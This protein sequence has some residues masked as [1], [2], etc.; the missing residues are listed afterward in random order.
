LKSYLATL[1]GNDVVSLAS[2]RLENGVTTHTILGPFTRDGTV[3]LAAIDEFFGPAGDRP[4]VQASLLDSIRRA[5]SADTGDVQDVQRTVLVLATPWMTVPEF[6]EACA[7]ARKL[8]VSI[9]TVGSDNYG[10]PEMAM[11]SGGFVAA[12]HEPRALQIIFGAMDQLLAGTVP[13]YRMQFRVR[14]N[15]G[16]F[17]PGGNAKIVLSVQVPTESPENQI[18]THVDVAIPS[19]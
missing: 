4:E 15:A 14:G 19:H 17:V 11:R 18:H 12:F 1:Q 7:L 5:A 9:S 6:N 10:F 2:L 8:G 16:T 13:Y 3:Y